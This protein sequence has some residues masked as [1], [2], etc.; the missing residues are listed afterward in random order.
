MWRRLIEHGAM[1]PRLHPLILAAA[2]DPKL[3]HLWPFTS[4]W[5]LCFSRWVGGHSGDL[6]S[7]DPCDD[8]FRIY[9]P[10]EFGQSCVLGEGDA[11]HAV[12]LLVSALP[13]PLEVLYRQPPSTPWA[14]APRKNSGR[15]SSP[16]RRSFRGGKR[17]S[18]RAVAPCAGVFEARP[19][20][21][22]V[23]LAL[24]GGAGSA[25]T[26]R[27]C[28]ERLHQCRHLGHLGAVGLVRGELDCLLG[29]LCAGLASRGLDQCFPDRLRLIS[30][31]RG[32]LG[33]R[34]VGLVVKSHRN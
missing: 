18:D 2:E 31:I 6:P 1:E 32:Q 24:P 16:Q 9:A 33:E 20:G 3:R 13:E 34:S 22:G 11:A 10:S 28:T 27:R 7:A 14:L 17:V 25:N 23:S 4:M 19:F 30:S 12:E 21:S 8:G 29:E 26:S 15:S 5:T